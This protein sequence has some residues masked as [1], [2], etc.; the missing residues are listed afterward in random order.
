MVLKKEKGNIFGMTSVYRGS[1]GMTRVMLNVTTYT[2]CI[3]YVCC[4]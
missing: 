1:N 3:H 4:L 2:V